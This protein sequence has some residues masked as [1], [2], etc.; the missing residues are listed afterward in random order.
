[1]GEW[2]HRRAFGNYRMRL[3]CDNGQQLIVVPGEATPSRVQH[4]IPIL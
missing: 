1:M 3:L 4:R 2:K